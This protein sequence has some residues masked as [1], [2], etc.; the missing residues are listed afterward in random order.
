MKKLF[1]AAC[2]SAAATFAIADEKWY[3]VAETDS[4]EWDLKYGTGTIGRNKAGNDIY[5]VV[6]RSTTIATKKI[7][8]YKWYV[9]RAHC[10]AQMG[11]LVALH[12]D[13]R[14]RFESDFVFGA[15]SVA[16][17]AA[18]FICQAWD[19]AIKKRDEKGI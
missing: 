4:T 9:E 11:S 2:L 10:D 15:G 14:F 6:V 3:R 17:S 5:S 13:G 7:E 16:A 18:E 1:A 12:L 8:V 19:H